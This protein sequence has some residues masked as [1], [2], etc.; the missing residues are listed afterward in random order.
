M[1]S[2]NQTP[3]ADAAATPGGLHITVTDETGAHVEVPEQV[4]RLTREVL[5]I[6]AEGGTAAVVE[7]EH[8]L[9]TQ[10]AAD[11]LGVSRPHLIKLLDQGEIPYYKVGSHRRLAV[12]DVLAF[13]KRRDAQRQ[14]L[15][16]L[17]E[18]S[19]ELGLY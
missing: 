18:L 16:E 2:K 11:I 10:A 19:Q 6:V 14:A 1:R 4:Y 5:S 9:T 7:V 17:T 12:G 3:D 15:K 8:D 13:K